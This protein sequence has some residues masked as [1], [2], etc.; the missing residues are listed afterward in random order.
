MR[1]DGEKNLLRRDIG[2][3]RARG[4]EEETKWLP[5]WMP[6]GREDGSGN[7]WTKSKMVAREKGE[8]A[9]FCWE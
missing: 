5:R 1:E 7:A 3:G 8:M 4:G 2:G 6:G 9:A